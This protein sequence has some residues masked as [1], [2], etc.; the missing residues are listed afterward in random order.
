MKITKSQLKQI[1]KEELKKVLTEQET[2]EL[3][4]SAGALKKVA[5]EY[6]EPRPDYAEDIPEWYK[7]PG[8]PADQLNDLRGMLLSEIEAEALKAHHSRNDLIAYINKKFKTLE[9][10]PAP[11][12][13]PGPAVA[14]GE[15]PPQ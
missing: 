4:P 5:G 3:P 10:E 7:G 6:V 8:G 1:I 2:A 13:E 11:E 9:P 14:T 15:A 12:P